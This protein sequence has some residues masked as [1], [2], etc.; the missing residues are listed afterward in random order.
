MRKNFSTKTMVR[1]EYAAWG[2]GGVTIPENVQDIQVPS[3]TC[4]SL[5]EVVVFGP[6]VAC[7]QKS[8]SKQC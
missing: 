6:S 2:S 8:F 3:T 7:N 5:A 4:Y 1:G